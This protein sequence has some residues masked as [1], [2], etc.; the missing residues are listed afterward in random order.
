M[1]KMTYKINDNYSWFCEYFRMFRDN[2]PA[3]MV[4]W[5]G[6]QQGLPT[7]M[8]SS[9][10]S[11]IAFANKVND[12]NA[13]I[14]NAGAGASSWVLRKLFKNVICTDP[15]VEYLDVVKNICVSGGISG[16]N[17]IAGLENVPV[18]DYTYYDYG[19]S[20][21]MPCLSLGIDKTKILAYVDDTDDRECCKSERAFVYNFAKTNDFHIADCLDAKDEY[22]RWGVFIFK[23][24]RYQ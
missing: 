15:D 24:S 16:E 23:E 1:E 12:E 21:R 2:A 18:C 14:L 20:V 11:M 4:E 5:G 17:F 19:N 6:Y 8:A 13:T 7:G 9:L 22:G 10:E 3:A